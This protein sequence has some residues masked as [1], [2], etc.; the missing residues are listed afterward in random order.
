MDKLRPELYFIKRLKKQ[1]LFKGKDSK[2]IQL[3]REGLFVALI[4]LF[5]CLGLGACSHGGS[6]SHSKKECCKTKKDHHDHEGHD[7]HHHKDGEA[8]DHSHDKDHKHDKKECCKTKAAEKTP[9]TPQA[10][11]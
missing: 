10:A 1:H 9:A 6:S 2:M 4:T 3:R 5:F 11:K 8:C 7:H